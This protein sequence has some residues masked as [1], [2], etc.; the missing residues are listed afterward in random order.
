VNIPVTL[1]DVMV[2]GVRALV[3]KTKPASERFM[4]GLQ[5]LDQAELIHLPNIKNVTI[6][7]RKVTITADSIRHAQSQKYDIDWE[8]IE[9]AAN[10]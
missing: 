9:T 5:H 10:L 1:Y 8:A 3:M 6:V 7:E 4:E 2:N